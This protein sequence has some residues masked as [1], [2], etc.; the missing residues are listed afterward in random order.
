MVMSNGMLE[1]IEEVRSQ[2]ERNA[3]GLKKLVTDHTDLFDNLVSLGIEPYCTLRDRDMN[4]SFA[5][6][7]ALMK[8]VWAIL[9]KNGF[10]PY[11]N[12]Q[13]TKLT[14]FSTWFEKEGYCR[15][16]FNFTSTVCRRVKVGT[17]MQEVDVYEIQC[18]EESE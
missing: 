2:M 11:S 14:A 13:D 18:G 8:Q 5:G 16:W 1:H 17:K 4:V 7:Y 10:V 15:I 9:R 3:A 6:D 12:P